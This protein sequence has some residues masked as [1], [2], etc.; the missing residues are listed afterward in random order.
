MIFSHRHCRIH[1]L[2]SSSPAPGAC[3]INLEWLDASHPRANLCCW[4]VS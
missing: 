2:R 3:R 1:R 4:L